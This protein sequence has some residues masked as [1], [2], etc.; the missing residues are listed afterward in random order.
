ML[1]DAELLNP[2][3][4]TRARIYRSGSRLADLRA[5]VIG[6]RKPLNDPYEAL[7]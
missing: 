1:V 4:E 7:R 2:A 5:R 3:G 6:Q